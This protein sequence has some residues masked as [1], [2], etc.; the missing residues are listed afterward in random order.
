MRDVGLEQLELA[1]GYAIEDIDRSVRGKHQDQVG[2]VRGMREAE[3]ECFK[4]KG[5]AERDDEVCCRGR[6]VGIDIYVVHELLK[7]DG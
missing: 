7:L 3:V 6:D 4:G 1:E 2:D 5:G